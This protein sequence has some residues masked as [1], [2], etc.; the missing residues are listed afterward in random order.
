MVTNA[1]PI[2][3]ASAGG[4]DRSQG[5][6]PE[7]AR[8]VGPSAEAN[9]GGG[10][11][12]PRRGRRNDGGPRPGQS[13]PRRPAPAG[14]AIGNGQGSR[15]GWAGGGERVERNGEPRGRGNGT[16]DDRGRRGGP[17]G[18]PGSGV[19]RPAGPRTRGL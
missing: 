17:T 19:G 12:G 8:T 4:P 15:Q 3:H 6:R 10:A 2:R 11:P 13:G 16:C 7:R 14:T 1:G 18:Y 5:P 9:R